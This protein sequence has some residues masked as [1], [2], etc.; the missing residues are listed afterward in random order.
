ME[1][2]LFMSEACCAAAVV[3]GVAEEDNDATIGE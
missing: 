1:R 3:E 2:L